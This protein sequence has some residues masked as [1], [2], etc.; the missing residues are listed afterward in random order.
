MSDI[1]LLVDPRWV[2]SHPEA[3]LVDLR[4]SAKG[5]AGREQYE[6]GH[7]AGAAFADLDRDLSRP[8]GPGRHPFPS[9]EQFAAVLSRLGIGPDTH[10][11]VY[12]E[13][14]SSVAAR[15]WFMLRAFGH[16][17][18][19]V[20]DGGLRAWTEVGLPLTREE[21]RIAPAPVRRLRLDRSRL[22]EVDEVQARTA[23]VLDARAPERYRGEIEPIDRKAGHIP[24]ALNAPFAANLTPAQK[25]KPP[26]EL[27]RL[28]Q[29]YGPDV[30]VSCGSG[31]T[32]C[33]DALAIELA[34]LPPARLYVGSFS[35]WI[36]D[37]DRPVA[38]GPEPG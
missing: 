6:Q 32:A 1:P 29:R 25:F 26:E 15:L 13:G 17:H 5:P 33:H 22:A 38:T 24:G 30:I 3:R 18:V 12:D 9:E 36:E 19:S 37:P 34:G 31:V 21:P 7:L 10:V 16:H 2:Q 11:V 20:L 23:P 4:W 8:G 14:H 27:R 28:Y 35:G